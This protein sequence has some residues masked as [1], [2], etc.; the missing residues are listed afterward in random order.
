MK[1]LYGLTLQAQVIDNYDG[2]SL[3]I[4][5][6]QKAKIRV[7]DEEGKLDTPEIGWRAAHNAEKYLGLLAKEAVENF[8]KNPVTV[9]IPAGT[10]GILGDS[11]AVGNRYAARIWNDQGEELAD[12]LKRL[13]LTKYHSD[14]LNK[15]E[16]ACNIHLRTVPAQSLE[17]FRKQTGYQIYMP[18][19]CQNRSFCCYNNETFLSSLNKNGNFYNYL[20]N[21]INF[22]DQNICFLDNQKINHQSYIGTFI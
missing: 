17:K 22:E 12:Y 4:E 14:I 8:C 19:N 20:N 15:M 6:T 11:A 21:I 18:Q 13:E 10:L 3:T 16:Q 5:V 7:T 1:P 9:H 2:D